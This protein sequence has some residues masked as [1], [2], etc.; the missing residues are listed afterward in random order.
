MRPL[1]HGFRHGGDVKSL[2]R[3]TGVAGAVHAVETNFVPVSGDMKARTATVWLRGGGL[4]GEF[5]ATM[6]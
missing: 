1:L 2:F 5:S 3:H 4:D 6:A